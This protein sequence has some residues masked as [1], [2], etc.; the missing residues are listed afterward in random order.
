[1]PTKIVQGTAKRITDSIK[2]IIKAYTDILEKGK[3]GVA[4]IESKVKLVVETFEE[5]GN[6]MKDTFEDSFIAAK[7]IKGA[8]YDLVQIP[9][10][11]NGAGKLFNLFWKKHQKEVLNIISEA[12]FVGGN[13]TEVVDEITGTIGKGKLVTREIDILT[14]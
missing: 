11:S 13:V 3:K 6:T 8:L 5:N 7:S 2:R 14:K 4:P 1:M 10:V 9:G 12:E